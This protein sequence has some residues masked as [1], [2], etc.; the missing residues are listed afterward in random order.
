MQ[1][2][3]ADSALCH[4]HTCLLQLLFQSLRIRFQ[5]IHPNRHI[6]G[7]IIIR[8]NLLRF[9]V[10]IIG[11]PHPHQP[12]RMGIRH[13]KIFRRSPLRQGNR[14]LF[15]G[16]RAQYAVHKALQR[17]ISSDRCQL[18][19]LIARRCIR[20]VHEV[21]LIHRRP[22]HCQQPR[23]HFFR[24]C[25]GKGIQHM[26]NINQIAQCTVYYLRHK[27]SVLSGHRTVLPQQA[28][29]CHCIIGIR[30]HDFHER[31]CRNLS[32][33]DLDHFFHSFRSSHSV[34]T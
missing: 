34:S 8:T 17:A 29:Q 2:I 26:V 6:G 13:R 15:L 30:R 16:R 9:F 20:Y 22:Q 11:N 27:G 3:R 7:L 23:L 5:R 25:F 33:I 1:C 28:A 4:M 10:A 18:H 19:R 21:H 32:W 12:Q 24:F 31:L 14:L